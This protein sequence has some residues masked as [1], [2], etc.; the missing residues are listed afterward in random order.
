MRGGRLLFDGDWR[1][2]SSKATLEQ[3]YLE[4][5]KGIEV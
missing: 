3:F 5:V 1:K 2:A 4:T